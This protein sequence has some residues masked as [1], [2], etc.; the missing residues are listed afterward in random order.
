MNKL[1]ITTFYA[2]LALG[3]IE[4]NQ[5]SANAVEAADKEKDYIVLT[6]DLARLKQDFNDHQG[7]LRLLFLVGPTCGG[8]L[9]DMVDIQE[10]FLR[11]MQSDPRVQTFVVHVPALRAQEKD[12]PPA[13]ELMNGPRITHYWDE[14]G[15]SGLEFKKAM[16]VDKYAWDVFLIYGADTTWQPAS[17]PPGPAFWQGDFPDKKLVEKVFAQEVRKQLANITTLVNITANEKRNVSANGDGS[18]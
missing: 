14:V 4:F 17:T 9:A 18:L 15:R 2:V 10:E 13:I 5:P 7:K 12:V 3:L 11:D 6:E 8:C 1:L 16:G